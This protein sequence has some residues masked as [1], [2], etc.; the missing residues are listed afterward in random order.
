M[1]E[2]ADGAYAIELLKD[3]SFDVVLCDLALP[4]VDGLT[5]F[6]HVRRESPGTAVII[7]SASPTYEDAVALLKEGAA[8]F[9]AKPINVE[10]PPPRPPSGASPSVAR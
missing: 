9:V 8:D 6:R 5:V 10:V 4:R 3:R 2:A 7:T 1:L